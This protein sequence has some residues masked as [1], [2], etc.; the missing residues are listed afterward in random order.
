[1]SLTGSLY[2]VTKDEL[3]SLINNDFNS[4]QNLSESAD[5]SYFAIDLLEILS[6]YSK[7]DKNSI[8]KIL[9]GNNSFNPDDG[10]IGYSKPEEVKKN[11]IEII[12]NISS[13]NFIE[14]LK[15]W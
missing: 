2:I 12:D 15:K 10:F 8:G 13:E 3:K 11:K 1:M 7:I 14:Y 5:L 4:I 9:Q 6:K